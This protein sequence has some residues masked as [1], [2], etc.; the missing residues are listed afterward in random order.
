MPAFSPP[1]WMKLT[2]HFAGE[3]ASVPRGKLLLSVWGSFFVWLA[4]R[5][6]KSRK[7]VVK[8]VLDPVEAAALKEK[9][10]FERQAFSKLR[11]LIL[12]KLQGKHG[13][14]VAAYISSL[15]SRVFVTVKLAD[16]GG[17]G[18][19]YFGARQWGNMFQ[20]QAE[21]GCWCMVG[22]VC[23][24]AMK[25]LEKRVSLS[26]R[27]ILYDVML[28]KYLDK[29]KLSFYR[30]DMD[31]PHSRLTSDLEAYSRE[32]T[33]LL[34]YFLKPLIDVTHL[35]F[36]IGSRVG[37]RA[38]GIFLCFALFSDFAL[39]R[40]KNSLPKS[41]K[42][43]A[44]ETQR[45]E[46]SLRD[47][48][49]KLHSSREQIALQRGSELE[50]KAMSQKFSELA[51]HVENTNRQYIL[52]DLLNTYI[53]KYGGQMVGFSVLI[54]REYM[55][56]PT[57]S[58]VA[59]ATGG[60]IS[61]SALLGA[62][63]NA[64][65]DL[66]DS[67]TE[68]PRVAGLASRVYKL[69]YDID[70]MKPFQKSNV[71]KGGPDS[72]VLDK[73]CVQ[74]PPRDQQVQKVLV[75]DLALTI[76]EGEHTVVR[77]KNGTGKSS[78]FRVLGGLWDAENVELATPPTLFVLPQDS[79]FPSASLADQVTY[80]KES[81]GGDHARIAELLEVVGLKEAV[82]ELYG[83]ESVHDWRVKLSG[84][85]KQKLAWA[86]LYFHKPKFGLIDEG[87]SAVDDASFD[88]LYRYAK[89]HGTTIITIAHQELNHH[90][91]HYLQLNGKD[92]KSV[93]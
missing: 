44:I 52:I 62:L 78:L 8:K 4:L 70:R 10:K 92:R 22:A 6:K 74:P 84:G 24:A 81:T 65:K 69:V 72:I 2:K 79:Y 47:R 59:A 56:D 91:T 73:V 85:Q 43:C 7:K 33:H 30:V 86:R 38:L 1:S 18:A 42:E 35:T 93:V 55:K 54:P 34:G 66:A 77:G 15:A 88:H 53:L 28:D 25:Y 20:S 89:E 48:H 12:P 32:V 27:E 67:F 36:V 90:H 26:V 76:K 68:V 13:A 11:D 75:K 45:L 41:L 31:D 61:D 3:V 82:L 51:N 87:T 21:F 39:K 63:A 83:L 57:L 71:Y 9:K 49:S 19:G 46:S 37:V 64:A 14:Y 16:A 23:G 29:K 58:S 80:P 60:F 17:K 50:K 5:K 40:V